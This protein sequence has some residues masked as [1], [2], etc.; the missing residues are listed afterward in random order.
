MPFSARAV[1][2]ALKKI[3]THHNP[4]PPNVTG[5]AKAAVIGLT[6]RGVGGLGTAPDLI[7]TDISSTGGTGTDGAIVPGDHIVFSAT[8]QNV[9]AGA[10]PAGRIHD[11]AFFIDDTTV[12]WS[13]TSTASLAAGATRLLTANSGPNGVNYW[14][15][16]GTLHT[17]KAIVNSII[18]GGGTDPN[19][20]PEELVLTNNS[21]EVSLTVGSGGGGGTPS[22]GDVATGTAA[23]EVIVHGGNS[24]FYA[25][26]GDRT[27][28]VTNRHLGG[29]A[30]PFVEAASPTGDGPW[31]DNLGSAT[32]PNQLAYIANL[33]TLQ[34]W[35]VRV[36]LGFRERVPSAPSNCM[37]ADWW[38]DAAWNARLSSS[39]DLRRTWRAFHN[40][41]VNGEM[42]DGEPYSSGSDH[43]TAWLVNYSGNSHDAASTLAKAY[44]RG[45]AEGAAILSDWP[46][47]RDYVAYINSDG[48]L[49]GGWDEEVQLAI[50]AVPRS[51]STDMTFTPYHLGLWEAGGYS[52]IILGHAVLYRS[53]HISGSNFAGA[54]QANA[55]GIASW[56]S[57]N[58]PT[59]WA[60]IY[61][62][63]SF[64]GDHWFDQPVTSEFGGAAMD[65]AAAEAAATASNRY[66]RYGWVLYGHTWQTYNY[67]PYYT[68][69]ADGSD[70]SAPDTTLPTVSINTPTRNGTGIN[71]TGY[72]QHADG[73]QALA[74]HL[75]SGGTSTPGTG[76]LVDSGTFGFT[77]QILSGTWGAGVLARANIAAGSNT[78]AVAPTGY[79]LDVVAWTIHGQHHVERVAV[80]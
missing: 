45:L 34:G 38:D 31:T 6:A 51:H 76:T 66:S 58:Y 1:A 63:I 64:T 23:S 62:R 41:G 9:G 60:K 47:S 26:L 36:Y 21:L 28:Y 53:T 42:R 24:D 27:K 79:H 30:C 44:Q 18:A 72:G 70:T 56:I 61:D 49:P 40:M 15:A 4:T 33:P 65:P 20:I 80:P 57:R 29:F 37:V 39:G 11:V 52:R 68:A 17:V 22:P 73:V 32:N 69:L 59:A 13:D 12:S 74:W 50:N 75:Y 35:G 78:V 16:S 43:D 55:L 2:A 14:T 67:S 54:I 5:A 10:T 3:H 25:I 77:N 46:G 48:Y 71:V 7:V 8:I 19:R